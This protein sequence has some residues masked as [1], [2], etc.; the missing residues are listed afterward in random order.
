MTHMLF[1]PDQKHNY[2]CRAERS[3]LAL[4]GKLL[5]WHTFLWE[6]E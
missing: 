5:A 4:A 2:F 3:V 1:M 6:H